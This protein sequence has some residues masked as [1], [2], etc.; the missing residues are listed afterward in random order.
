MC[1]AVYINIKYR[2]VVCGVVAAGKMVNEQPPTM[3]VTA[4][5]YYTSLVNINEVLTFSPTDKYLFNSYCL[6]L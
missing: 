6:F 1:M 5:K 3:V 2:K 4:N